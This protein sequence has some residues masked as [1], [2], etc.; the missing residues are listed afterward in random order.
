MEKGL[1]SE[2]S[3][4]AWLCPS[5]KLG[6]PGWRL[7][8]HRAL[9][10]SSPFSPS[11]HSPREPSPRVGSTC[12]VPGPVVGTQTHI[13]PKRVTRPAGPCRGPHPARVWKGGR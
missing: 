4:R 11:P 8:S 2:G 3:R 7:T 5:L 10:P 6:G 1:Q 12:F 9:C 13:S